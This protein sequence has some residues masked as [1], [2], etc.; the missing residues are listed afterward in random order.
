MEDLAG[1]PGSWLLPRPL[2]MAG[3]GTEPVGQDLGLSNK[4]STDE[5][6]SG[7]RSEC[8]GAR[9]QAGPHKEGPGRHPEEAGSRNSAVAPGI[10]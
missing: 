8:P 5:P 9:G 3:L 7:Q 2:T 10:S 6:L 4:R 1:A